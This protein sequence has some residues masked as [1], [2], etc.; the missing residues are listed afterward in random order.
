MKRLFINLF[1][2][3]YGHRRPSH[4]LSDEHAD[5]V[6]GKLADPDAVIEIV[7]QSTQHETW[8]PVR[9]VVW[10]D[11]QPS[12]LPA[13]SVLRDNRTDVDEDTP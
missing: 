4:D 8:I 3:E 6:R 10:V 1:G 13:G 9:S 11:A 7:D 5:A 12:Q 2:D